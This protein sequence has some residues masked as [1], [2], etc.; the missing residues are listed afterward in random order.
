[1]SSIYKGNP[2]FSIFGIGDYSFKPYKVAI[3]GLYK[4]TLFSL[5]VPVAGKCLML[6]D[7]N[8]FLGF[9]EEKT[10]VFT[11]LLLNSAA[12]QTFLRS[13]VFFDN[14]RLITKEI[15]MRIDLKKAAAIVPF[16]EMNSLAEIAGIKFDF[17]HWEHELARL[18]RLEKDQ[19]QLF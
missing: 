3:S 7:T 1:K 8:Y 15:L 2:P 11:L 18:N 12:V 16:S 5:V 17:D 9:E 13:I 19:M 14:K 4:Q 6:D 10:A